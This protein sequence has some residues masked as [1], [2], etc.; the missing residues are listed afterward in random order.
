LLDDAELLRRVRQEA[1]W[2]AGAVRRE[3]VDYDGGLL[4]EAGPHGILDSD[5]HWW[6]QA[7]AVVGFLNAWRC[8]GIEDY[9][10][11]SYQS[12]QFIEKHLIDRHYGEWYW[13]VSREGVPSNKK[14]K[15][16]P[17]K[18]PYH[19]SRACLEVLARL[20]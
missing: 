7:E 5:K 9:F 15:I 12:W 14:Y 4:Y 20:N 17:W 1:V 3:A 2:M 19:N 16:D 13:K 11:S 8:S 10:T 6:P 18:G